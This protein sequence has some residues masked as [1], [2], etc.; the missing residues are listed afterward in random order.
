MHTP[1]ADLDGL[2]DLDGRTAIV[3][4]GASG[5]GRQIAYGLD[6]FGASVVVA[7]VDVPG[8]EATTAALEHDALVVETDVTD[9]DSLAGL[10]ERTLDAF[11]GYEVLFNV[12]GVNTRVPALDL[13]EERFLEIVDLN[14]AGV[15]RCAK[16][17]GR[18]LVE[19]G[20]GSVVNVASALGLV[21]LP[22]QSAYASSKGGVVQLTKVLAAEWA[23]GVRVNAIAPGYVETPLVREA[24]ADE[25]WYESMRELHLLDRFAD[26]SEVVGGAVYLASGASSFVT[27]S[28]L[29]IDGGW[30]AR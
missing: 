21:G 9:L 28:V 6:A 1:R 20:R 16:V 17:L 26:P 15:F 18:P 7:D 12:P 24:M 11:G 29:S 22:N 14:L 8:A 13:P 27:G 4:G 23:P 25:D 19:Q 30:T 5:I 2:F 3:T 10:R